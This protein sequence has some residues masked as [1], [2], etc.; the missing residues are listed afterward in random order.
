MDG[1]MPATV[2][3]LAK[4]GVRVKPLVWSADTMHGRNGEWVRNEAIAIESDHVAS[5]LTLLEIVPAEE[6]ADDCC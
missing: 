3:E 5:V 6:R 4:R 1:P 2:E